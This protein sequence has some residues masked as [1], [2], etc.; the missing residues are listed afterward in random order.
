MKAEP[1]QVKDLDFENFLASDFDDFQGFP[2]GSSASYPAARG[3]SGSLD[4]HPLP[5]SVN[6]VSFA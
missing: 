5:N 1:L 6:E 4:A 2:W 3:L